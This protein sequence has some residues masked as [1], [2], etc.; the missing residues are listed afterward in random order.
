MDMPSAEIRALSGAA[1]RPRG[2]RVE[3][4]YL[5][6]YYSE[7]GA[8]RDVNLDVRPGEF[9]TFLG[10]SG[11]GK[12]TTL[13][14]IAGFVVPTSGDVRINDRSIVQ[15]PVHKRG[16]GMVFQNYALFPHLNVAR[17]VAFPLEM[18]NLPKAEVARRVDAVLEL[19]RLGGLRD[20]RPR[21]LSGGQ[22]QR[23]ALARALV[24]EPSVLLLDEPLG[25]LDAK[26]REEMKLELK[27]LHHKIGATVLFVT[28]DQ[29][30]ALTLSDRIAVF[31]DGALA[32]VG[33]PDELYHRPANRFV[34]DFIGETNLLTGRVVAIEG[35]SCRIALASGIEATG[36]L[37]DGF[38][39]PERWAT[40]TLRLEKITIGDAAAACANHHEGTVEEFLFIGDSTKYLVRLAPDL[41]IT[42]KLPETG[43]S[44]FAAGHEVAVGWNEDDMLLVETD[45]PP[46]AVSEPTARPR[47]PS[48]GP[49]TVMI[50]RTVKGGRS[51]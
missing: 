4:E 47:E 25:A 17:N 36:R 18:R 35:E 34:A 10:P 40:Y 15:V 49:K 3:I 33:T 21:Q 37:R 16:I 26:L 42:V 19:V 9:L 30:E 7:V 41:E 43:V 50:E 24:F 44:R 39:K 45:R 32:Q 48:D 14:I 23:V 6:K 51:P 8:N 38:P 29:E 13:M 11:S 27:R 46:E 12:T 20:R 31:N 28:H 2:A 5:T 1:A 22:Q